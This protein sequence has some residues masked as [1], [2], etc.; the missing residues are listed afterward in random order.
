MTDETQGTARSEPAVSTMPHTW[1]KAL[2]MWDAGDPVPAFQV[3][4]EGASQELL[5]GEAF[6]CLAAET[7]LT[8][9]V[10]LTAREIDVVNSIV[11]VAKLVSWPQMISSHV[12]A[13]SPALMIRKPK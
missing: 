12:G 6:H 7:T 8:G 5:W 11:H 1:E 10:G 13:K 2:E 3:E 9:R 4:S